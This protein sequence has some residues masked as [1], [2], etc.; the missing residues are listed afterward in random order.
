MAGRRWRRAE[1]EA[2]EDE[3]GRGDENDVH[4]VVVDG[5]L[6]GGDGV[7]LNAIAIDEGE[8]FMLFF[9]FM[10]VAVALGQLDGRS[11][12]GPTQ[13]QP[14]VRSDYFKILKAQRSP[15]AYKKTL[16]CSPESFDALCT[17]LEP[18]YYET[19]GL[20]H[21]NTQYE[22][23]I[24]LAVLLTYYGNGCG[25]DGDGIGG[26]AAQ[27]GMSRTCAGRFVR[28]LERI[29]FRMMPDVV[30]FPA[31]DDVDA[32]EEM[33]EGFKRRG[34]DFPRV[35]CVF[36][37]TI[38][39][40]K[41][42]SDFQVCTMSL[43]WLHSIP[44]HF[45]VISRDSMTKTGNRRTTASPLLTIG[46]NFDTLVCFPVVIPISQCGT[47]RRFSVRALGICALLAS[48]GWEI[49][50]SSSGHS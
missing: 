16:R 44:K 48:I 40:T 27:I 10:M 49:R 26:A 32:W 45:A 30:A 34:S 7:V 28:Q 15:A 18:I 39:R 41:R 19:Y 17:L 8:V 1:Y 20:P 36:D 5:P 38:V 29:L 43:K 25:Q 13:Q 21:K 35:A 50:G 2:E 33:V 4:P 47:S 23:D 46:T 14:T 24:K 37:G 3:Q 31:S 42:P 11:L 22:F 9:F 12:R 6:V